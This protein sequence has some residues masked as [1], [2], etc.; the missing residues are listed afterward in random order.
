MVQCYFIH[1]CILLVMKVSFEDIK[2]LD[3]SILYAGHPE[4]KIN[5]GIET[6]TGPLGQGLE[7]NSWFSNI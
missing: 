2:I 1:C 7:I 5:S 6:T 4:F 3:K